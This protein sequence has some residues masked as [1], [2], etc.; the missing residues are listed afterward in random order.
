MKESPYDI[1]ILLGRIS[2]QYSGGLKIPA[3]R[4]IVE[5][6]LKSATSHRQSVWSGRP[7]FS[8]HPVPGI[9]AVA[10]LAVVLALPALFTRQA[11]HMTTR[12]VTDLNVATEGGRVVLTWS[13]GDA[14]HRVLRATSRE[15]LARASRIPGEVVTGERWVDKVPDSST[16]VYYVVE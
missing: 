6:G 14:P 11:G 7:G 5:E 3:R 12:P 16:I 4:R 13:D 10:A 1:K 15:D 9:L 8:R 2:S